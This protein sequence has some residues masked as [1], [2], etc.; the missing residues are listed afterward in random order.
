M[1]TGDVLT[2]QFKDIGAMFYLWHLLEDHQT[3]NDGPKK[4]FIQT[5]HHY[6]QLHGMTIVNKKL[7]SFQAEE[8]SFTLFNY[9]D[10]KKRAYDYVY[11]KTQATAEPTRHLLVVL[12]LTSYWC[13][14]V[15]ADWKW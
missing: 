7:H 10:S 5:L 3:I 1:L 4:D 6:C 13:S 12:F 14:R 2:L 9:L 8:D 11:F 15:N